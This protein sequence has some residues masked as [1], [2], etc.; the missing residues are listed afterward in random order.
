MPKDSGLN[1]TEKS[2]DVLVAGFA[3]TDHSAGVQV[4]SVSAWAQH[5][6]KETKIIHFDDGNTGINVYILKNKT[7][8]QG[9]FAPVVL[10][11][12]LWLPR[13]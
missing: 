4:A 6:G 7:R 9:A 13:N 8:S 5:K 1:F 3:Q 12:G 2:N 11:G 10:Q